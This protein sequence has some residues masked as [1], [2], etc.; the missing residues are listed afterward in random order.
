M[1][2]NAII[3][4]NGKDSSLKHFGIQRSLVL[5][6]GK[7]IIFRLIEQLHDAGVT[8]VRIIT[9]EQT[10]MI[11]S[12]ESWRDRMNLSFL[13]SSF[14]T[15]LSEV[16]HEFVPTIIVNANLFF[17]S[18]PFISVRGKSPIVGLVDKFQNSNQFSGA[19][20]HVGV[21]MTGNVS[22]GTQ[23]KKNAYFIPMIFV[24]HEGGQVIV[25]VLKKNPS[26]HS[27]EEI[28]DV[29]SR[30]IPVKSAR[31]QR[32]SWYEIHSP[33]TLLRAE[34]FIRRSLIGERVTD[35]DI[36]RLEP[37]YGSFSFTYQKTAT[38]QIIIERG[39]IERFDHIALMDPGRTASHH[40]I[41][42]EKRADDVV[43]KEVYEKMC[44]AG[45]TV[46]K[47]VVP[48]GEEAKRIDVY[49]SLAEQIIALGIDERSIIFSVG[50][51]AVA[52]IAGFLAATLY[53]GVGL[54][55]IPT[56]LMCMLDVAISLKQGINSEKG[57]NLVGSYYQPLLVIIDPAISIPEKLVF[58]GM[59]EAIKHALTQDPLFYDFLMSYEGSLTDVDFIEAVVRKTISLKIELMEE[60]MFENRR[61]I[62]LQYGH[63]VGHAVEYISGFA[64]SHGE[65]ISIGM[66]VSAQLACLMKV[67]PQVTVDMHVAILKK[68][69]LPYTI[70]EYIK[71]EAILDALLY[72]KKT[73]GKDIRFALVEFVGKIW[74][75]KGEFG[76]PCSPELIKEAIKRSYDV[77]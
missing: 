71:E 15:A 63:E 1:L 21:S 34:M 44:K 72:N 32:M 74:K 42:T 19:A 67:A 48:S 56:T 52:N 9:D 12:L 2:K 45:Y 68:Y 61:A 6:S 3:I 35:V 25:D 24:D 30:Q 43:G 22:F 51:G 8:N 65:A 26:F 70:P 20:T 66:R 17:G 13:H 55:H 18:N 50:G 10:D 11:Q 76:I 60:D 64:L 33:E 28:M 37:V 57:K 77:K 7:P 49:R 47:L 31:L 41:I 5:V 39:V 16:L 27:L 73:R 75:I 14:S 36:K 38:T 46:T 53:R 69:H 29:V 23:E 58:D 59:S 40:I 54:I 62:A 4:A